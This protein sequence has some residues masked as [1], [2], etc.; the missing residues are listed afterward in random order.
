VIHFLK[1]L[2]A[3]VELYIALRPSGRT[4]IRIAWI[5][6]D[7]VGRQIFARE[8][9][10]AIAPAWET[11]KLEREKPDRIVERRSR[12]VGSAAVRAARKERW[13]MLWRVV[14]GGGDFLADMGYADPD[15][16]RA[17][18]S[19]ANLIALK[20]EDDGMPIEQ[21]AALSGLDVFELTEIMEGRVKDIPIEHL[22]AVLAALEA[23]DVGS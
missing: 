14:R 8:I 17:K 12:R 20:I 2:R 18:I 15:A 19:V 11:A 10:S 4:L 6:L 9:R 1:S 22:K 23:R 16:M 5:G 3:A 13:N 21:A 7:E